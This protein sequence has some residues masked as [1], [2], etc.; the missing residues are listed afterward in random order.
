MSNRLPYD[1]QTAKIDNLLAEV[2]V[3]DL[4]GMDHL[5]RWISEI[6]EA[7]NNFKMLPKTF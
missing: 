3:I 6:E 2:K 4:T 5:S 1:E 7:N